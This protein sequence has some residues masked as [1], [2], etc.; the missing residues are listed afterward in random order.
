MLVYLKSLDEIYTFLGRQ[1]LSK[2]NKEIEKI[3][4][5]MGKDC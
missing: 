3:I 4:R 1:I 5:I 2:Y